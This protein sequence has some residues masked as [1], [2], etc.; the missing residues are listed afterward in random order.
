MPKEIKDGILFEK[1]PIM[2]QNNQN[3]VEEKR[4]LNRTGYLLL[5]PPD[6]IF[7]PFPTM[8]SS[9]YF[10]LTCIYHHIN[11]IMTPGFWWGMANVAHRQEKRRRGSESRYYNLGSFSVMS[12]RLA[13]PLV[14]RSQKVIA[15]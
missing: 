1:R 12:P 7:P 13:A 5:T 14:R 4:K 9:P 2:I 11:H 10:Y 15:L 6:P 3:K 8:L